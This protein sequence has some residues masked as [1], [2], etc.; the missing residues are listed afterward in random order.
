MSLTGRLQVIRRVALVLLVAGC[1]T[2]RPEALVPIAPVASSVI[3]KLEEGDI[4]KVRVYQQPD[5]SSEPLVN[6]AG[7]AFFPGLGR[8]SVVG[9]T[10]DSLEVILT[11]QY[12][13]LI[14]NPAVQVTMQREITLY[15]QVRTPGIYSVEPSMTL[16][17][18]VA[19]AGGQ[20]TQNSTPEVMLEK[21]DGRRMLMPREARVGTLDLHRGDAVL[22]SEQGFLQKN[23][24]A[25]SASSLI[26]SMLTSVISLILI[27]S[28]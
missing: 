17:G 14:R 28:R 9:M 23:A 20:A 7:S 19:R 2:R 5:L 3:W 25:I 15:G 13:K 4:L 26:A 12:G 27:I 8:L 6:P 22:L 18:V 10:L 24:T 16:M 11:A 21:A 1:A